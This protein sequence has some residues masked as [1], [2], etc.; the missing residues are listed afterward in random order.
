MFDRCGWNNCQEDGD[1]ELTAR[2][3]GPTS[4]EVLDCLESFVAH[5]R[6]QRADSV[7]GSPVDAL[8]A[9]CDDTPRQFNPN[10]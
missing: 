6:K 10:P 9:A 8:Q 3:S 4:P 2:V 1:H 7:A 5:Q